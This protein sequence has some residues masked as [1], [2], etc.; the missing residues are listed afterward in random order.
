M[1]DDAWTCASSCDLATARDHPKR[2]FD[3]V[4]G[5]P[6]WC[7]H[8]LTAV[9]RRAACVKDRGGEAGSTAEAA[10]S[11]IT[12]PVQRTHATATASAG[13][14]ALAF[15]HACAGRDGGM[16]GP[17]ARPRG[18]TWTRRGSVG[19]KHACGRG[20]HTQKG[21]WRRSSTL[22]HRFALVVAAAA[23]RSAGL[24]LAAFAVPPASPP[25]SS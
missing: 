23:V 21:W 14:C 7:G 25:V 1:W 22:Q 18:R 11:S 16:S 12:N 6:F 9:V 19:L 15:A 13:L 24:L 3:S 5:G 17:S 20:W 2:H 4:P 10:S 8:Q